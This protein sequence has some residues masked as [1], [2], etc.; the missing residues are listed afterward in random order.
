MKNSILTIAAILIVST[1]FAQGA[2]YQQAMGEALA[3]FS[4]AKTIE[5]YQ[6]LG[7]K[8][9]V[10]AN[11][12]KEEWLPLYYHAQCYILMNFNERGNQ[13]KQDEFLDEAE[14]SIDN[15]LALA[16]GESE[17]YVMQGL[18]YSARLMV[19]PMT[20]GQKY[21]ALS[22]QSIGRALGIEPQNPRARYMQIANEMGTARFF[23]KDVSESCQKA[24]EL[25]ADWDEYKINS[26]ISPQWGKDQVASIVK[27][28]AAKK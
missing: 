1:S 9:M 15:M 7:N 27:Q 6:A 4:S 23:G 17:A 12:E 20:R 16:P 5:D 22:G 24:N 2:K 19:D 14:K 25:Y 8:F 13:Q 3:G 18:L 10:I 26:R 21:S 11:A 28:C